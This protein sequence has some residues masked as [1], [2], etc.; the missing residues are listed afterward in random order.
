[1]TR[2]AADV[3]A[4]AAARLRQAGPMGLKV[5]VDFDRCK[6]HHQCIAHCPEVFSEHPDGWL[7]VAEDVDESL[8]DKVELAIDSC[9]EQAISVQD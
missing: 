2:A 9:P 6:D 8:R 3:R 5:I 7:I 4:A 1:V